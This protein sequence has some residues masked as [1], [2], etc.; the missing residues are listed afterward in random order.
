M[1]ATAIAL[2]VAVAVVSTISAVLTTQAKHEVQASLSRESVERKKAEATSAL[3]LEALDNIFAKF[4]PDRIADSSNEALLGDDDLAVPV[5]PVLSPEAAALL[6]EMLTFYGRLAAE[7]GDQAAIRLKVAEAN[8]RIGDI[9]QRLGEFDQ[10]QAAYRQAHNLYQQLQAESG[11]KGRFRYEIADILNSLG[12][13]QSAMGQP[14]QGRVSHRQALALLQAA[15]PADVKTPQLRVELARTYYYLGKRAGRESGPGP[16]DSPPPPDGRRPGGP[17]RPAGNREGADDRPGSPPRP[18]AP[19][20]GRLEREDN[21]RRAV[22][23]LQQLVAEYPS[24]ADYGLMLA[25]C[26]RD[27]PARRPGEPGKP[28]PDPLDQATEILRRL[29]A[30][31]PAVPEYRY[32]LCETLASVHFRGRRFSEDQYPAVEQRLCEALEVAAELVAEHPNIPDYAASEVQIHHKL[33]HVFRET[34]RPD[35]A[36]ESLR[37]ALALQSALVRQFPG[38]LSY[39]VWQAVIQE[40]LAKQLRPDELDEARSLLEQ[41]AATLTGCLAEEQNS[42][43]IRDLLARSYDSL[44]EVQARLG[45]EEAAGQARARAREYRGEM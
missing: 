45:D 39:R 19:D 28:G 10:A 20:A 16:A 26:C 13:L 21:L 12:S 2:L 11:D 3:A 37:K 27:L 25:R 41:S 33:A 38:A 8:R 23:I 6:E 17:A 40:S 42:G 36:E 15:G 44:A 9:H 43:N 24:V 35:L 30:E 5:Q 1:G 31:Y 14:E 22:E 29:V 4:A 7:M 32:E 18:P 34:N